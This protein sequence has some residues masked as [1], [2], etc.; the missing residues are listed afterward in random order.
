M[1]SFLQHTDLGGIFIC[2]SFNFILTDHDCTFVL[3]VKLFLVSSKFRVQ[4]LSLAIA[5]IKDYIQFVI[6]YIPL[7]VLKKMKVKRKYDEII[8]INA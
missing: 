5:Y 4:L 3:I 7:L 6:D 8:L 2:I 1:L